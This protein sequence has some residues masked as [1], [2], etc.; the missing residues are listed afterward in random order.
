MIL[1]I[2][3]KDKGKGICSRNYAV[4]KTITLLS[5]VYTDSDELYSLPFLCDVC[6]E[7]HEQM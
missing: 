5:F 7:V 4:C 1:D 6:N 3:K 2:Q